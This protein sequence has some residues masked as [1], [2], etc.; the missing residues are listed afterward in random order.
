MS[1]QT[2]Q[3]SGGVQPFPVATST[4]P[5]A[6]VDEPDEQV[7]EPAQIAKQQNDNMFSASENALQLSATD[8][9]ALGNPARTASL[10]P[11]NFASNLNLRAAQI[12]QRFTS[13][14]WD[15]KAFGKEF[16]GAYTPATLVLDSRRM[17]EFTD[18]SAYPGAPTSGTG[19]GPFQFPPVFAGGATA[20][21]PPTSP[22][23][24][25]TPLSYTYT[26]LSFSTSLTPVA[27]TQPYPFRTAIANLLL[28]QANPTQAQANGTYVNTVLPQRLLSVNGLTEQIQG[29]DSTTGNPIYTFRVRPLTPHPLGLTT[30]TT[31][32]A[33]AIQ[34][35]PNATVTPTNMAM[36][37]VYY[38]GSV[39]ITQPEQLTAGNAAQQE[40]LARYDRQR[41]ARDIYTLLYTFGG[42]ND[43]VNYA[44]TSNAINPST[45]VRPLYTEEQLR[46]MAQFAV[47]TVDALDPDDHITLFEYDKNLADG[48]GLDDNPYD[49]GDA[50]GTSLA[51]GDRG[52]VYGVERQRLALNESMV[53]Y[54]QICRNTVTNLPADHPDT[55]IN[56]KVPHNFFYAELENVGPDPVSF[57]NQGWQ[58]AIKESPTVTA[59]N[60]LGSGFY[61]V[62]TPHG[63]MRL[64][65]TSSL[66]NVQ[67]GSTGL[68]TSP[69]LTIGGIGDTS[70]TDMPGGTPGA[71]LPSWFV[72]NPNHSDPIYGGTQWD[73]EASTNSARVGFPIVPLRGI[74]GKRSG[75]TGHTAECHL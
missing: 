29:T 51:A 74:S 9:A 17:W 32:S 69:R 37:P 38:N 57:Q 43:A 75:D 19:S 6:N 72:V 39:A 36:P 25:T 8:F 62:A 41:L 10:A 68:G 64:T 50:V 5:G 11:F 45:G 44:A 13:T 46:E 71:L 52:I 48:W 63:E 56:D 34:P 55:Q 54:S 31:L 4:S 60:P 58:I 30:A 16:Y 24:I 22:A 14:S 53:I 1:S 27:P 47:N 67:P 33:T 28:I 15:L 35:F 65:F 18:T 61:G 7:T 21:W 2:G 20:I 26:A 59:S 40:W 12:R 23:A 73:V 70:N 66:P 42:G 49:G 3:P